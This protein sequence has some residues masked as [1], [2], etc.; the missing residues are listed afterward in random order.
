MGVADR[1]DVP[2]SIRGGAAY[3]KMIVDNL[4]SV[5][6]PDR[7]WMALASYNMGPGYIDRARSRAFKVGDDGNKWLVVSQHLRN[8]AKE[9]QQ[10][11][12]NIPVGQALHYVQQVRRYYDA[13]LLTSSAMSD[14]R[15][16]MN[17]M[18]RTVH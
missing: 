10:Q 2:Q 4:Q 7:T 13:L 1:T 9:A 18:F 11:G 16:A 12:R 14:N 17:E 6:E 3:Y 5:P 15:V 8:M